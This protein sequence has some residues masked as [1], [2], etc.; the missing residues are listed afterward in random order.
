[1]ATIYSV[2]GWQ[3]INGRMGGTKR[4]VVAA[5]G[6]RSNRWIFAC[7]TL[8]EEGRSPREQALVCA[9]GE[10]GLA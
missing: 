1:M 2:P 5:Y 8:V 6:A 4:D 7:T 9:R 10:R 3:Y